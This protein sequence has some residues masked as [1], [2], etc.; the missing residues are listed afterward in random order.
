MCM[1]G[2]IKQLSCHLSDMDKDVPDG[3]ACMH[4]CDI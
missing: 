3:H 4:G 2:F 1:H